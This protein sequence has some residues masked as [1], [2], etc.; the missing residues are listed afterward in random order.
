MVVG[1]GSGHL[2]RLTQRH[3]MK[4]GARSLY[5]VEEVALAVGEVIKYGSVKSATW[6]NGGCCVVRREGGAGLQEHCAAEPGPAA[7]QPLTRAE[8]LGVNGVTALEGETGGVCMEWWDHGKTQIRMLCQQHMLNVTRLVTGSIRDLETEIVELKYLNESTGNGGSVGILKIK[9]MALANLLGARAQSALVRS[10][11]QDISEMD[12]PSSF[13]FGLERKS[14]QKNLIHSLLSDT[15]Q[16]LSDPGQIRRRAVE[17]YTS[18]YKTDFKDG[19]D[20]FS[21]FSQGLP[22]VS[23]ET[24][25]WMERRL[26]AQE[27]HAALQTRQGRKALGIDRFSVERAV[28][29]FL[30]K[31]GNLQVIK[32]CCPV[33]LLCTDY[34]ILAKALAIWLRE[35]LEQVIHQNQTYYQ[36]KAFDRFEHNF[37]WRTMERF[38]FS[39]GL[40]AKIHVLYSNIESVLKSD[41][42]EGWPEISRSVP[43]KRV[44]EPPPDLLS[45]IQ[46]K[47]VN[48]F[49]DSYHWVPQSVLF[50]SRDQGGQGLIHLA[51]KKVQKSNSLHWLLEEPLVYGGRLDIWSSTMPRLM[52]ALCGSRT[53]TLKQLV[54][55]TGP[56]LADAQT[57]STVLGLQSLRLVKRSLELWRRRLSV[58]ERVLLLYGRGGAEPD[59]MD[60]FPVLQLS[61]VK[62]AEQSDPNAA[63]S[64][65]RSG[66]TGG[67]N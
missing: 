3:G 44:Y 9:N 45:Q 28:I 19:E 43:G 59:P 52:G 64:G 56:M 26:T 54:E 41:L 57:L 31:K 15:G 40:I 10:R 5:T 16:E 25:Y 17:F 36:E 14:G 63:C 39:A 53:V 49:W 66:C 47:L 34:K 13:F 62:Q 4:V 32:N 51:R 29:T 8:G 33:S 6:M 1:R 46:A 42:E 12:A 61:P 65:R 55:A 37:L 18:L 58:R 50:L 48:Y 30:P 27:L 20:C 24:N 38:G 7:E 2:A 23:K 67:A 60:A 11:I 22:R 21:G 35:A